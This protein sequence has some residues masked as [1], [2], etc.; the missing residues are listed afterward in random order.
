MFTVEIPACTSM[1]VVNH[2]LYVTPCIEYIYAYEALDRL[3]VKLDLDDPMA[4]KFIFLLVKFKNSISKV[5]AKRYIERVNLKYHTIYHS[6]NPRENRCAHRRIYRGRRSLDIIYVDDMSNG[7]KMPVKNMEPEARSASH[8]PSG[9][10][11]P[12]P[13][14]RSAS[15]GV[16]KTPVKEDPNTWT[17]V[18]KR[19]ST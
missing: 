11:A 4:V 9:I 17:Q 10:E 18:V 12:A 1:V 3:K 16:V 14:S 19:N 15:G 2:L 8:S 5:E 13:I 6:V 7:M